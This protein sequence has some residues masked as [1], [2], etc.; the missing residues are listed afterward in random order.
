MSR[1]KL[2]QHFLSNPR[3]LE[4]IAVAAC[5][6]AQP[7]VIEIGPGKGALTEHLLAR[8][9]RVIA[10]EIDPKLVEHLLRK[11]SGQPRLEI[12]AA[13]ALAID[14]VQWGP[15]VITGNL[16]YYAATPLLERVVTL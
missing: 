4:R 8:A 15:A 14:L 5:D 9:E 13:D 6:P 1:Q 16:P 10:I 7:L 11:F 12:V 2:G 3:I